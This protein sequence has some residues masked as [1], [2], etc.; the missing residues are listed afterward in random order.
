MRNAVLSGVSHELKTPLTAITIQ[1]EALRRFAAAATRRSSP[2]RPRRGSRARPASRAR[3]RR[4]CGRGRRGR[5]RR[6]GGQWVRAGRPGRGRESDGV[7]HERRV[8]VQR[9][10]VVLVGAFL[11]DT[12][13]KDAGAAYLV[14]GPVSGTA[15]VSSVAHAKLLGVGLRILRDR[16]LA[17]DAAQDAFAK[18]LG[19]VR[20]ITRGPKP[21]RALREIGLAA[22]L[23]RYL[24]DEPVL[25]CPPSAS[26]RLRKFARR[27]K[28]AASEGAAAWSRGSSRCPSSQASVSAKE[29]RLMF[30]R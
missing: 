15:E 29:S 25:A 19:R 27:N 7:L 22:D 9:D 14:L 18:A 26:Y 10:Q 21:V 8:D 16:A 24:A 30:T 28:A 6:R 17:E 13:K 11:D 1:I 4:H 20:K 23:Q 5:R 3:P 12:G 2:P